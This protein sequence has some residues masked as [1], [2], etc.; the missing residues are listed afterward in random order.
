ME[1]L[2]KTR[3]LLYKNRFDVNLNDGGTIDEDTTYW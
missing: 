1:V 2:S 3:Y